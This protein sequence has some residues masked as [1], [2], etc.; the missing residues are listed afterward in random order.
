MGYR[1]V[2]SWPWPTA[3]LTSKKKKKKKIIGGGG[4]IFPPAATELI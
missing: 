4:G 1:G 3:E 2:L